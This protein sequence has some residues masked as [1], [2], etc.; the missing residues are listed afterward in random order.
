VGGYTWGC[1]PRDHRQ[2]RDVDPPEPEV[3]KPGASYARWSFFSDECRSVA[4]RLERES[5]ERQKLLHKIDIRGARRCSELATAALELAVAFDAWPST[6]PGS[7]AR[8]AQIKKL[9]DLR[10]AAEELAPAA[11]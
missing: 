2:E 9:F 11:A 3:L 6:D 4:R 1:V 7:E 5:L 10:A 8:H